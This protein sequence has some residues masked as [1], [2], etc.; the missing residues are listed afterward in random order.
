[1][2]PLIEFKDVSYR[3]PDSDR[4][5]I[6]KFNLKVSE[7]EFVLIRGPSG[8]GKTTLLKCVSG[9]VPNYTGGVF[10]GSVCVNGLDTLKNPVEEIALTVG[11]VFQDPE[12]QITCTKVENEIAFGL[13]NMRMSK[14]KIGDKIREIAGE[15]GV[16]HLLERKVNELSSGEK[17][18]VVLASILAMGP[19]VLLLDEPSSQLDPE[20]AEKLNSVLFKLKQEKNLTIMLVEHNLTELKKVDRIL[21]LGSSETQPVVEYHPNKH[22]K[23][24]GSVVVKVSHLDY[25][26]QH[27]KVLNNINLEVNEG[28]VVSIIGP[29]GA[30]KTTLVKHFNGLLKPKT[31]EVFVNNTNTK[32]LSVE[33]LASTIGFLSQNP[34]DYLFCDTVTDELNFTLKNLG[35]IGNVD[36]TLRDFGLY[37]YRDRYPRDL[38]GGERQRVALASI[39]VAQPKIVVLDEPTRGIDMKSKKK[40]LEI[41]TNMRSLGRTIILATHDMEL[42]SN[43]DRVIVM[44]KGKIV[45]DY[46]N[47]FEIKND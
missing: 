47:H 9:L 27:Q 3:Y 17:Q 39:L 28:E 1:M 44:D 8:S 32:N 4:F 35:I 21:N 25:C 14:K 15:V 16:G 24:A 31:G 22:R 2:A 30:G 20:S 45:T 42:A 18:K 13:E 40:L 37:G 46:K 38:S 6:S 26:Y 29:N 5:V 19:K 10:K 23:K 33:E 7:R 34:N 12:N 41:L 43:S 36:E 11:I